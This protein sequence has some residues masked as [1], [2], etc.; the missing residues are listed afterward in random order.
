M[1][2]IHRTAYDFLTDSEEG[3]RILSFYEC[4]EEERY[5]RLAQGWLASSRFRLLRL[6][7]ISVSLRHVRSPDLKTRVFEVLYT[8]WKFWDADQHIIIYHSL[9]PTRKA[10]LHF[11]S[12]VAAQGFTDFALSAIVQASQPEELA[13]EVLEKSLVVACFQYEKLSTVTLNGD[14]LRSLLR[15]GADPNSRSARLDLVSEPADLS[16]WEITPYGLCVTLAVDIVYHS[17]DAARDLLSAILQAGVTPEGRIL[18]SIYEGRERPTLVGGHETTTWTGRKPPSFPRGGPSIQSRQLRFIMDSSLAFLL[19]VVWFRVGECMPSAH[20]GA[21]RSPRLGAGT[22]CSREICV[23]F[24]HAFDVFR[25]TLGLYRIVDGDVR[26]EMASLFQR[27]LLPGDESL[28]SIEEE[29][30][31]AVEKVKLDMVGRPE[32]YEEVEG[33]LE[34]VFMANECCSARRRDVDGGLRA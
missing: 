21:E 31:R 27:W 18:F 26:A 3:H 33:P 4:R 24:V 16:E 13:T 2:F 10:K 7:P 34:Y 20:A 11:L 8:A 12:L 22:S 9:Q 32:A 25:P 19:E 28:S 29:V 14:F 6:D 5:L 17:R 1:T 23:P 15:L 30:N